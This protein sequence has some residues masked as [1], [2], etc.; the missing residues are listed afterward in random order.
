MAGILR[1]IFPEDEGYNIVAESQQEVSRADF[2]AFK[3]L[4]RPGGTIWEYDFML[5]ES[6]ARG[7][8]WGDTED[9]LLDHLA[10]NHNESKNCYG[11]IQ[12][13][14]EVQFYKFERFVFSR[15]GRKMHL[16][17]D[18]HDVIREGQRLKDNP[19]QIL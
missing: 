2:C 7:R 4:R 3:I 18:V 6:K 11:M 10:G 5:I 9:H 16:I 1:F 17:A 15:V 19:L 8:A 14:L 12:I 13:G